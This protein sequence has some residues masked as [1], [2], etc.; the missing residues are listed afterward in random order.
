M[1][2]RTLPRR[3]LAGQTGLQLIRVKCRRPFPLP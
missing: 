1:V 2:L 3:L